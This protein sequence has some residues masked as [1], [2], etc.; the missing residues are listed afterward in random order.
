MPAKKYYAVRVGKKTGIFNTWA[1]CR[2]QVTG[3]KNSSYKSFATL[4]EAEAFLNSK[5][6]KEEDVNAQVKAYV[7]GSYNIATKEFSFGAVLFTPQG[8]IEKAEKFSDAEL[9]A[10]RNVA[11]ELKGAEYAMQFCLEH[12]YASLAIYY[13]YAGIE[14]WCSGEWKTNKKGTADYKAYFDLVKEKVKISFIKVAAHTGNTY[15]ERVDELAK[16]VLGIKK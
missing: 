15:N 7:D 10:M 6:L 3:V 13:D 1:E 2:A 4:A 16:S 11:G 5:P 14:K 12:G 8:T 9:A